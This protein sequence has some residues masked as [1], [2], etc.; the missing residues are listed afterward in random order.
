[1][2]GESSTTR[3]CSAWE[4]KTSQANPWRPTCDVVRAGPCGNE[5]TARARHDKEKQERVPSQRCHG[6]EHD[7]DVFMQ[8]NDMAACQTDALTHD[9]ACRQ[10]PSPACHSIC[11]G[12]VA[13]MPFLSIF[14]SRSGSCSSGWFGCVGTQFCSTTNG[15]LGSRRA[16]ISPRTSSSTSS[17][18]SNR[19]ATSTSSPCVPTKR[20]S[21]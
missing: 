12:F 10:R 17:R 11:D 18:F 16:R 15:E 20:R 13:D 8:M 2:R 5:C 4:S 6:Q 7:C 14:C 1:M 3:C 21:V 9:I 19:F